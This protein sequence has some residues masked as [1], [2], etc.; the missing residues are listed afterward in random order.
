MLERRRQ[1]PQNDLLSRLTQ[2][3]VGEAVLSTSQM[4]Y[5]CDQLM[6]AGRDLTTGLIGNCLAAVLSQPIQLARLKAEPNRIGAFVEES[7][8]WDTPVLG[9]ARIS[10]ADTELRGIPIPAGSSVLVMFA[11]ANRDPEVFTDPDRF[12]IER[13]NAGQHLTFGRGIH[14]CIGAALARMEARIAVST[15][16]SRLPNLRLDAD[17]P[18]ARRDAGLM[19]NLRAYRSL[20][21]AFDPA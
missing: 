1:E 11:A 2:A 20:P 12:D 18:G 9:Q 21:L 15:L 7:L 3:H 17:R 5:L 6:V 16:L 4:L 8:R 19:V 10:R 13:G 14:F